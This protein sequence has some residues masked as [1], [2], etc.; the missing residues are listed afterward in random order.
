[1]NRQNV[2]NLLDSHQTTFREEEQF[3]QDMLA[4]V[5]K[6]KA[7]YQRSTLSGHLTSSAWVIS[8]DRTQVLLIFHKKLD[9]WLQPGGHI[10]DTD[11]SLLEAAKRE[12]IEECGLKN[13]T[14]YSKGIFDID[15]HEIPARK[16]VPTHFHYDV[17]FILQAES[18]DFVA[19]FSEVKDIKWVSIQSIADDVSVEQS[20]RRMALKTVNL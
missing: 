17:R 8:P 6:H 12:V 7:F 10:D 13:L 20:V 4:F 14:V 3:R 19:D 11:V 9:K 5:H 16:Q 15:I 2:I 18:L 1:M